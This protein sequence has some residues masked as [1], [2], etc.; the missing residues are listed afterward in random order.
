MAAHLLA[1]ILQL[2]QLVLYSTGSTA[3]DACS[4]DDFFNEPSVLRPQ[5][6]TAAKDGALELVPV[7]SASTSSSQYQVI[8]GDLRGVGM[9]YA[10]RSA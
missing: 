4:D 2:I 8:A 3:A 10:A 1:F 9:H 5:M 6:M 7:S